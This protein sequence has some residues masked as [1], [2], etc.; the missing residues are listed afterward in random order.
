MKAPVPATASHHPDSEFRRRAIGPPIH[1]SKAEPA[2]TGEDI[3]AYREMESSRFSEE[4]SGLAETQP[5]WFPGLPENVIDVHIIQELSTK[6]S[7]ALTG[8]DNMHSCLIVL[9]YK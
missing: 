9:L 7:A 8:E 3:H 4:G 5:I 2:K 6:I 1:Q